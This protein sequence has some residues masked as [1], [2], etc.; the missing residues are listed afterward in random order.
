MTVT[1]VGLFNWNGNSFKAGEV[2]ALDIWTATGPWLLWQ[3]LTLHQPIGF[4]TA[5]GSTLWT[6]AFLPLPRSE[7]K[8]K[9]ALC[10]GILLTLISN[11]E[12]IVAGGTLGDGDIETVDSSCTAAHGVVWDFS[13]FDANGAALMK[14]LEFPSLAASEAAL[15]VTPFLPPS[16]RPTRSPNP[17]D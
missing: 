15:S 8:E 11:L 4:S 5:F 3:P 12:Y 1:T 6:R 13:T 16:R 10:S 14:P 7:K 9:I 17:A 2:H